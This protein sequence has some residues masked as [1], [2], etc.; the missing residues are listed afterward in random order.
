MLTTAP[1]P[2]PEPEPEP[3]PVA[4]WN[5]ADIIDNGAHYYCDTI[6][7]EDECVLADTYVNEMQCNIT[8]LRAV[9]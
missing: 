1:D 2:E 3:E 8:A 5:I 4:Y 7:V 9:G 6:R